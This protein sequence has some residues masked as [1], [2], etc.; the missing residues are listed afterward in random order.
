MKN[1]ELPL[2][3]MLL[4]LAI[5]GVLLGV[6]SFVAPPKARK[7]DTKKPFAERFRD[8]M[9]EAV[10]AGVEEVKRSRTE[11]RKAKSEPK[12]EAEST[13]TREPSAQRKPSEIPVVERRAKAEK[14]IRNARESVRRVAKMT[15]EQL[16]RTYGDVYW[17]VEEYPGLVLVKYPTEGG[18]GPVPATSIICEACSHMR[19]SLPS[20]YSNPTKECSPNKI[21]SQMKVECPNGETECSLKHLAK[22]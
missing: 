8:E 13:L 4:S 7:N 20:G 5:G 14:M 9:S 11:Q 17:K 22:G 12:S 18:W 1:R 10:R 21:I 15:P 19:T 3:K 6:R 16:G 2:E